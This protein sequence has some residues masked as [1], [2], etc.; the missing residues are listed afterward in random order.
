[1]AHARTAPAAGRSQRPRRSS[2][3]ARRRGGI[4]W[5]RVARFSLLVV[6]VL[7]LA[8]YIGPAASYIKA[9][10][11]SNQ[12]KSELTKLQEQNKALHKRYKQLHQPK[13][14]ELEARRIGMAKPGE[15]VYVVKG[16]PK[17]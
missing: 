12:T 1:M 6:L 7:I 15:K 4:R 10:N 11:F 17:R 5:D 14:I 9:F 16:L 3:P 13:Q 8:S 2:G